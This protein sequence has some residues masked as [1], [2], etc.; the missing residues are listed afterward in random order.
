MYIHT[1]L[2][3][4]IF[5]TMRIAK[6]S[7]YTYANEIQR[8]NSANSFLDFRLFYLRSVSALRHSVRIQNEMIVCSKRVYIKVCRPNVSAKKKEPL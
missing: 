2:S 5:T 1:Y 6:I 8:L 3:V 4:D 7:Q